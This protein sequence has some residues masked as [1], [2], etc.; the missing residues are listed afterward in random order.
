MK[1]AEP[2]H[3]IHVCFRC[4]PGL[5]QTIE[6][7]SRTDLC[8]RCGHRG[9]GIRRKIQN[10]DIARRKAIRKLAAPI[11]CPMC[12]LADCDCNDNDED[13]RSY[14]ETPK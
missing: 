12:G 3:P 7:P 11:K 13:F 2:P 9:E 1:K 10:M 6:D 5:D 4:H 14:K 8:E